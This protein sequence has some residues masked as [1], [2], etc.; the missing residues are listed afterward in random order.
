MKKSVHSARGSILMETVL[1]IPLY[2]V[3][4]SGI[5]WVGDV[6][7]LRS[8]STFFDRFAAW[9]GGNRHDSGSSSS[10][11]SALESGFLQKERVGDQH[12]DSVRTA[13][14]VSGKDWSFLAG[15]TVEVS[16]EPPVWTQ[17][18]RKSGMIMME[19]DAGD[20]KR[21]KFRSREL[22]AEWMHRTLMRTKDTYRDT[23]KP[24]ALAEQKTWLTRVYDGSWPDQWTKEK[25]R[26]VSGASNCMK[27]ERF[28]AY[29]RWSE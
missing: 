6:A 24:Q 14:G 8:K 23:V 1:V 29:V 16:I 28:S 20:L 5:F 7:L 26:S 12:V 27:Y 13:S 15:G 4:L 17:G 21:T 10:I 18:W 11:K 22:D 25:N 3:L 2:L 19:S 9:S